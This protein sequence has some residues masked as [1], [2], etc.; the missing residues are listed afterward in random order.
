MPVVWTLPEDAIDFVITSHPYINVF[1]YHQQ[2]R[3]SAE[4]LGLEDSGS[5]ESGNR[6]LSENRQNRFL[7]VIQYCLDMYEVFV[8]LAR[9][10][11]RASANDFYRRARIQRE[12]DAL[13]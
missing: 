12:E 4:A 5:G 6:L 7:T 8:E 10:G 9:V 1:N 3:A 13:L 11:K 2:Y